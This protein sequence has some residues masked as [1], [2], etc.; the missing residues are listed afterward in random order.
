MLKDESQ[1]LERFKKPTVETVTLSATGLDVHLS[2]IL[3]QS[4]K[5]GI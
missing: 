1:S 3:C 4:Q 5:S 2:F